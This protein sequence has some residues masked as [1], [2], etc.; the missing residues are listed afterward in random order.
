MYSMQAPVNTLIVSI[1]KKLYDS[2]TFES[3]Q[4]IFFDPSWHP[5]E[6][7]MLR[8]KVVSVPRGVI[9]R[10]DYHGAVVTMKPGDDILM[11]Y[12]VVFGYKDQPENDS[13]IYKNLVLQY[14]DEKGRYEELWR[15]DILQVFA[16]I[17]EQGLTM[18]NN[19]VQLDLIQENEGDF[20][21]LIIR[22]D[23]YKQ[24]DSRQL[25]RVRFANSAMVDLCSGDVVYINPQT[26]MCYQINLDKFYVIKAHHIL[27]KVT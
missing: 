11:R 25:A 21:A 2:V 26:V 4:T 14:N 6:Y 13:P 15:C 20:S 22:P 3:G 9:D 5:E 24:V 17:G 12:D 1:D 8:A 23:N 18:V 19:Y 16:I 7:A 10:H 27:A